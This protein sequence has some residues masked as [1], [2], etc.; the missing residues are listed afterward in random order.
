MYLKGRRQERRI[1]LFFLQNK[2]MLLFLIKMKCVHNNLKRSI[3]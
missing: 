2:L 3:S 1:G